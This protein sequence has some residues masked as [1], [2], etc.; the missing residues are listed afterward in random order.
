MKSKVKSNNWRRKVNP[1]LRATCVFLGPT[2][3]ARGNW[4]AT[5]YV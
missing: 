4:T 3:I 1:E 5:A 2:R